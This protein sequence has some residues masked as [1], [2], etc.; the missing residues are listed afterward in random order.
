VDVT[1][2]LTIRSTSGNPADT[3][4]QA[5]TSDD[6]VFEIT[7]DYVTISGFTVKGA[8]GEFSYYD[9]A[10]IYLHYVSHC[11]IMNNT[12]LNNNGGILLE[13][14]SSNTIVNNTLSN[15]NWI[16]IF[17]FMSSSN[18]EI[19]NNHVSNSAG[20]FLD[21]S[22]SN[23]IANNTIV[24]DRG[25][26]AISYS[27][28]NN[29]KIVNNTISNI[30]PGYGISLSSASNNE[31]YL[32][33]FI[34]NNNGMS[35]SSASNNEIYLNNFI[36][37]NNFHSYNSTNIWNS[38]SEITYT[39]NSNTFTNYLGNYRDDYTDTDANGDGIWDHPYSI[40]EGKDNYPLVDRFENYVSVEEKP[41]IKSGCYFFNTQNAQK[42]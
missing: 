7:T 20:I 32:N 1:K 35:L 31:I 22:S 34:N 36:N 13:S 14:S 15:H 10:G 2:S 21:R 3:I 33:N 38:T 24:N 41:E 28:S 29:N 25:G 17:L 16:G 30:S 6:H 12:V 18:N 23:T 42:G 5:K 11:K 19:A 40:D 9:K 37:N 27:P 39:Y 4:V 8:T 26:I